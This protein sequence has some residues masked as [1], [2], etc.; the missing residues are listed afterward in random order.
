[1]RRQKVVD[2]A[3]TLE[4]ILIREVSAQP[5]FRDLNPGLPRARA[6]QRLDDG[7]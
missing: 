6:C 3:Q 1:V 5:L 7:K 4:T 2:T